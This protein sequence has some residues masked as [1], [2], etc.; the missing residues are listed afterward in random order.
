MFYKFLSVFIGG[1]IGAILRFSVSLLSKKYFMTP[2]F[3]TFFVNVV[4][5]FLIGLI[6]GFALNKTEALSETLKIFIIA[7]FLGGLTTFSTFNIEIFEFLRGGKIF[8]GLLYMFLSLV[9]GL[10]FTYFGYTLSKI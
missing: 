8:Q 6:F 3:G 9:F 4:G 7:G 10:F 1:G 5:C 2:V